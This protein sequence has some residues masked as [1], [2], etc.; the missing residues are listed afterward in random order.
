VTEYSF[1]NIICKMTKV[2]QKTKY[3]RFFNGLQDL[4]RTNLSEEKN[5]KIKIIHMMV[6]IFHMLYALKYFSH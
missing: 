1:K 5:T 6:M 2:R 3:H 4:H